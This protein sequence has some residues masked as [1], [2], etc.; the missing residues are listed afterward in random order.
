MEPLPDGSPWAL[1]DASAGAWLKPLIDAPW[2]DMHAVVPR[3]FEAYARIFHPTWRDRPEGTLTWHGHEAPTEC[4]IEDQV[5]GWSVV[6][7]A[8]GKQ[9]HAL[10]QFGRLVGPETPMLGPLDA[11]GWRYGSPEPGNLPPAILAAAAVHLSAHTATPDRGV[12]AIWNGW[13]GLSSSAGYLELSFA[14]GA[15]DGEFVG[16]MA[17]VGE[18]PGSGLLPAEVVNGETLE[19]P[20]RSY[21]LFD[22]GPRFYTDPGWV[23]LAPWH[24]SPDSPQSPNILWPADRTWVLVSEIDFDSTVVAGSRE[25]IAALAQDPTIEALVL[26]EGAD[27]TWDADV[28]NRPID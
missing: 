19:L 22:A 2:H 10:A 26:Q 21:Y 27:L 1:P 12:T 28:P 9:M 15:A 13:G 4:G 25:L 23:N 11:A 17:T 24:H 18:G 14:N 20:G 6:A 3:G 8:F 5:V 7:E 16:G